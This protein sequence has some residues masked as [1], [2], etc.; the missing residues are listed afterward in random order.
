M[1]GRNSAAAVL[2][3]STR[4]IDLGSVRDFYRCRSVLV[5]GAGGRIGSALC[6]AIRHSGC[7]QISG[8]DCDE[9]ALV[10]LLGVD[11]F[12]SDER[13]KEFLCNV[14]DPARIA[15]IFTQR[16]PDIVLHA[17]ALKPVAFCERHAAECVLTNLVGVRNMADAVERSGA[18]MMVHVSSDKAAAPTSLV[19]ACMRLAEL[20]LTWRDRQA[21]AH[22]GSARFAT[23]RIGNVFGSRGSVIEAFARQIARGGPVTLTDRGMRRYFMTVEEAVG[24]ILRAGA[25]E[26]TGGGTWLLD[27]GQ[28]VYIRDVAAR[29][30]ALSGKDIDI[31]A[32]APGE[33]EKLEE[34]LYDAHERATHSGVEGVLR[35]DTLANRPVT[36]ND[37]DDL[38]A[39]IRDG[40]GADVRARVFGLLSACLGETDQADMATG[41]ESGRESLAASAHPQH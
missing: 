13:F 21:L 30:I 16:Q 40:G 27:V 41:D 9:H 29:M 5:A 18:S 20:H 28:P 12:A 34:D 7:Q 17:A 26:A 1:S 4:P 35:L 14:R 31:V 8:L 6:R 23:V 15:Q 37:I 25:S 36:K 2:G 39:L 33:S 24:L 38:E 32:C 3:R 10:D 19:G 22:G 11:G